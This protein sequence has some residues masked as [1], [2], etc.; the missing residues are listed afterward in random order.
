MLI[1]ISPSKLVDF[2]PQILIREFTLPDF[3]DRSEILMNALRKL[4]PKDIA[5]LMHVN[6]SIAALNFERY[7]NWHL[8]FTPENA[9][10]AI[11]AFTGEV[12]HGLMAST[13]IE[14][15]FAFAQ[16]HLRILSGLYGLLRP[17]DLIQPYR[18]EMGIKLET[19]KAPNLYKF[20]NNRITEKLNDTLK[21]G[22]QP[23]LINMASAE[24]FKAVNL[25]L[26]KATVINIEFLENKNGNYQ[27]IV[28][29]LKKARGMLSRFVIKNQLSDPQDMK[30]FDEDGYIFNQRLSKNNDWVFTRK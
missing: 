27:P 18:L 5:N 9:K 8:P 13:F 24:Y 26:L 28:V 4:K 30:A 20:W 29:Y 19:P 21:T 22:E 15:D 2:K 23:Y 11:L 10:Q 16:G 7:I 3:T 14:R 12:Y 25:K 6:P 1:V 17:L